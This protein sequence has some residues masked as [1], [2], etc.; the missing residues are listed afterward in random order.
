M[1]EMLKKFVSK[2]LSIIK[3]KGFYRFVIGFFIFE[4]A[5]IAITAAYPQAFDENFHFGLIKVYSH[6]WLPFLSK[7]PPNADAYGAVARDPS[8]L[9]HYLMSFPY[10][11][12]TLFAKTQTAQVILLR[13]IN[14]GFFATGLVLFRKL[15]IKTKLSVGLSNLLILL[16]A[17][18]PVVPQL[19]GQ[20][21]YDNLLFPLVAVVCLLSFNLIDQIKK[22]E[23]KFKTYMSL[24]I[25]CFIASL[26]KYAFLPIFLAITLFFIYYLIKKFGLKP[27]VIFTKLIAE[28]KKQSVIAKVI[29]PGLLILLIGMFIQRDGYNLVRYHTIVPDCSNVLSTNACKEYAPWVANIE[30][31]QAALKDNIV[32]SKNPIYYLGQWMYWMWY[33]LFFAINGPSSQY[34]NY[35]PL[36]LPSAIAAIAAIT[37]LIALIK[38]RK[39]L[40]RSNPYLVLLGVISVVY[41]LALLVQGY[42]TYQFTAVLENMNGRYLVPIL[43]LLLAIFGKA[44]TYSLKKKRT[45]AVI[46]A[47]LVVVLFLEGGGLLTFIDRSNQN[48]DFKNTSI[49]KINNDT[50]KVTKHLIISGKTQYDT[51]I[52]FFN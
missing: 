2:F 38:Y 35:P 8:Y 15:L 48:W 43:F 23:P 36:P 6:Y 18:I 33:R 20:I 28:F 50:R 41:I 16:V 24:L 32:A 30:R 12:I 31:H 52:W 44:I 40:F 10:R 5:W 11:I 51:S 4:A 39:K 37:G 17:L 9:Y 49:I 25:V 14:I 21:N 47:C 45:L 27:G 1:R 13:F 26:V 42:T 19:A 22:A 29:L 46:L 7:Q 34:V 3:S